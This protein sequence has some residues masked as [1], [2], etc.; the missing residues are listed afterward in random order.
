M[1]LRILGSFWAALMAATAVHAAPV[2][3]DGV[4]NPGEWAGATTVT[5][6]NGGGTGYLKADGSYV[7][8]GFDITG[9]TSAMGAGSGGNLLGFGVWKVNG[10]AFTS[11][12]VEVQQSLNAGLVGPTPT[13][14]NGLLSAW[15]VNGVY[16]AS[17]PADLMAMESFGTGYR[18]W[19]LKVPISTLGASPGDT[20]YVVGGIDFDWKQHWYPDYVLPSFA[21]YA[22][23][24]LPG[25]P[26]TVPEPGSLAL[27][28]LALLGLGVARVRKTA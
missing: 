25:G 1:K 15:R 17:L 26:L 19:E 10:G 13:T 14:L 4:I 28:G 20:I 3:I 2:T 11:P 21:Q 6:G 8:A 27:V 5:I 9:W 22:P 12:G 18:V 24:K 16:Q 7:Y 23:V